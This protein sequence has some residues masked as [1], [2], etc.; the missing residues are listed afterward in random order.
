MQL[1]KATYMYGLISEEGGLWGG[2]RGMY[3]GAC[4]IGF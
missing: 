3:W 1:L 2:G 4:L